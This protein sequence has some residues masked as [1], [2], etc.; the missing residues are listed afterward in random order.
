MGMIAGKS[1]FMEVFNGHG[2]N[3]LP[4]VGTFNGHPIAAV[5][6]AMN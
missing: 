3:S 5:S 6:N 1:E 2:R 4:Q